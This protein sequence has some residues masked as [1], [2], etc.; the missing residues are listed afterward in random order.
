VRKFLVSATL[1][2]VAASLAACSGTSL[3]QRVI[4]GEEAYVVNHST[5]TV[6]GSTI[7]PV[8]LVSGK[9]GAPIHLGNTPSAL[10]LAA[11]G[12]EL[13]VTNR[14]SDSLSVLD[15]H[16]ATVTATIPVGLEPFAVAVSSV[17]HLAL[18][19]DFGAGQVTPVDLRDMKPLAPVRVG[20]EPDAVAVSPSGSMAWVA[21]FADH[22][23]TP[24]D[25]STMQ[26][27]APIQVGLE[28]DSL[29][30]SPRGRYLLVANFGSNSLT[31]IDTATRQVVKAL[32]IP[33]GPRSVAVVS[34]TATGGE[35][36]Y[37]AAGEDLWPIS[38][39]NF[40]IRS[41]VVIGHVAEAV[42]IGDH[43]EMAWVADSSKYITPVS[44]VTDQPESSIK[45][46]GRPV[47]I[48]VTSKG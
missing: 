40:A 34:G 32:G 30:V 46:G 29:A 18:V 39:R 35:T 22:E 13:L 5:N 20:K 36:A 9:Q 44:L 10:A 6:P 8:N 19:A 43:G 31:V 14:G 38:I 23:V 2:A 21:D 25:L 7:T 28:P 12:G 11:K 17:D 27:L 48:V 33:G 47:A 26:A 3:A 16:D 24:V 1:L 41:P 37:V 45:V 15:T 4:T 42:A